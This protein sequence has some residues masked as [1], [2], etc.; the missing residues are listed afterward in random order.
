MACVRRDVEVVFQGN[1]ASEE[2]LRSPAS[3]SNQLVKSHSIAGL[4]FITSVEEGS[5]YLAS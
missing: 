2:S 3:A 4:F 5:I 1:S